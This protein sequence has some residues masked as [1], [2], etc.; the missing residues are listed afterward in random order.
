MS[1]NNPYI[2][3]AGMGA[4]RNEYL[5]ERDGG[6]AF[7]EALSAENKAY[8]ENRGIGKQCQAAFMNVDKNEIVESPWFETEQEAKNWLETE[9]RAARYPDGG[10]FASCT[11]VQYGDFK[12]K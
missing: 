10:V 9:L 5:S 2:S 8:F 4:N 6:K 12:Y 1:G 11:A 3:G 7:H